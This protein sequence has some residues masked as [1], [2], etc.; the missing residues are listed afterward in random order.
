MSFDKR[1]LIAEIRS[2]MQTDF[3]IPEQCVTEIEGG[4]SIGFDVNGR[5]ALMFIAHEQD[6]VVVMLLLDKPEYGEKQ[7]EELVRYNSVSDFSKVMEN[8]RWMRALE[9]SNSINYELSKSGMC[10]HIDGK[11]NATA[12]LHVHH[13]LG[14][15]RGIAFVGSVMDRVNRDSTLFTIALDNPSMPMKRCHGET[16]FLMLANDVL[17]IVKLSKG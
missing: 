2:D 13:R 3:T 11:G 1:E 17:G 5:P 7:D 6:D 8:D 15:K 9:A 4:I 10:W 14:D 16:E 12:A